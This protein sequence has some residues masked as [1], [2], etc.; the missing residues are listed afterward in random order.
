[1]VGRLSEAPPAGRLGFAREGDTIALVGP[2]APSLPAGELAKLRG[3]A[4]PDGLPDIDIGAVRA[5]QFAI[6]GAV[7]MGALSSAHDIAEGG[8]ATALAECCLAGGL[9]AE[10]QLGG[11]VRLGGESEADASGAGGADP[12]GDSLRRG[13]P[14]AARPVAFPSGVRSL[15]RRTYVRVIGTVRGQELRIAVGEQSVDWSLQELSAA[16]QSLAELFS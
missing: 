14:V 1:M 5:A 11:G 16:H 12:F 6:R 4:L 9:G 7:G 2:F 10:V 13:A 15:G 8:L 3:Q